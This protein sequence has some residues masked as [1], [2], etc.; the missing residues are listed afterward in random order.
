MGLFGSKGNEGYK[1]WKTYNEKSNAKDN[2]N[3]PITF[4]D[5]Y[6]DEQN[7]LNEKHKYADERIDEQNRKDNLDEV[8]KQ[9]DDAEK[10]QNLDDLRI[11]VNNDIDSV[12]V[13]TDDVDHKISLLEDYLND[14]DNGLTSDDRHS[15]KEEINILKEMKKS[16]DESEKQ[17]NNDSKSSGAKEKAHDLGAK[18]QEKIEDKIDERKAKQ[19]AKKDGAKEVKDMRKEQRG[20]TPEK[21]HSGENN[22][23]PDEHVRMSY[24]LATASDDP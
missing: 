10:Q 24:L 17:S 4:A 5:Q 22:V 3:D 19:Q 16:M 15:L 12:L 11:A 9:Q 7:D 23:H 14:H 20:N 18:L 8:K 1:P 2:S 21:D 6:I 13:S